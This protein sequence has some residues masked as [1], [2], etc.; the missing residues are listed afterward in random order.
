M[1]SLSASDIARLSLVARSEVLS[2]ELLPG[3]ELAGSEQGDEVVQLA[4]IVLQR[5]RREQ[6]QIVA[7]EL[8]NEFVAGGRVILDL[9]RLVDDDEIP[10]LAQ[11]GLRVTLADGAIVRDDCF[12]NSPPIV[13]IGG[14]IESLEELALEL[15]LPLRHQGRRRED[16]HAAREAANSQL[17][18]DDPRLDRFAEPHF[19]SEN[20]AA[21]HVS[22]DIAGYLDLMRELLDRVRVERDQAI[23]SRGQRDPL[24]LAS[25]GC[26]EE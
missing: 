4:E 13:G 20:G 12:G 23:E 16:Q 5:C 1:S 18:E 21:A 22:Q 9:V 3:A 15:S 19:V 8:L 17:L 24:R 10:S 25:N 14:R 11:D 2:P 6:E 7:I 26:P